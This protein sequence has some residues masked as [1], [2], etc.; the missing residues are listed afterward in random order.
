MSTTLHMQRIERET[1]ARARYADHKP[2][3]A[4]IEG[5]AAWV[6]SMDEAQAFRSTARVASLIEAHRARGEGTL[7][8]MAA[9]CAVAPSTSSMRTIE[10]TLYADADDGPMLDLSTRRYVAACRRWGKQSSK[11]KRIMAAARETATQRRTEARASTTV[12]RITPIVDITVDERLWHRKRVRLT[13]NGQYTTVVYWSHSSRIAPRPYADPMYAI[14]QHIMQRDA[15]HRAWAQVAASEPNRDGRGTVDAA[16]SGVAVNGTEVRAMPRWGMSKRSAITTTTVDEHGNESTV[17]VD[18]QCYSIT[19]DEHGVEHRTP[20][21]DPTIEASSKRKSKSSKSK[22]STIAA[23]QAA[24]TT[25]GHIEA[26][27]A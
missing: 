18:W 26:A 21:V 2:R 9:P 16:P 5:T 6:R 25:A 24:A 19:V 4:G 17:P 15:D 23:M 7:S 1:A 11:R 20:W 22:S 10:G 27:T 8:D 12:E 3:V 14:E 13:D